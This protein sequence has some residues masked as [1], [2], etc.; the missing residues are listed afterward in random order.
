MQRS[1][2]GRLP[3]LAIVMLGCACFGS[4]PALAN[5][6]NRGLAACL[7]RADPARMEAWVDYDGPGL[8]YKEFDEVRRATGCPYTA[9]FEY[10]EFRGLL[11]EALI[12]PVLKSTVIPDFSK[13]EAPTDVL[14]AQR[15]GNND[16]RISMLFNV[17]AECNTK[18]NTALVIALL[19]SSPGSN[20]EKRQT[21]ALVRM[22]GTCREMSDG[23]V[24]RQSVS[25]VRARLALAL[26][27]F[28]RLL[29]RRAS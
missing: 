12:A 3:L 19:E 15:W 22:N 26:Y 5:G 28:T 24:M 27:R 7:A 4:V 6:D 21:D 8:I 23:V 1:Q 14:M 16:G 2:W 9:R 13:L 29:G 11:A 20:D 10:W 25:D 18:S 17:F